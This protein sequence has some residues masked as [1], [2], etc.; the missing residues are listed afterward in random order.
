MG[1]QPSTAET[2]TYASSAT[3]T[4]SFVQTGNVPSDVPAQGTATNVP[5]A[6]VPPTAP[7]DAHSHSLEV[8]TPLRREGWLRLLAKHGLLVKYP[9]LPR[10]IQHGADAG[11]PKIAQT[12]IPPNDPSTCAL[13][14]AFEEIIARE[15]DKGRYLGPFFRVEVE[16]RIGPFQTSPLSMVPKAGKP[17]K[18]R[19][20]QNLS[21]PRNNPD[22]HSIN[23]ALDSDAFP[24][25][26]GTFSTI[27]TLLNNLPP[28]SQGACRDVAE[29]YHIIP[30]TPDQWPGMVVRLSGPDEFAINKCNSF[31]AATAGGLTN[32]LHEMHQL[33]FSR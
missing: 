13:P 6:E 22:T 12:Y 5:A 23:H 25:T 4:T 11:I 8:A 29:A 30:L 18:F 27:C 3:R 2:R 28:G 17:G 16:E 33:I 20:I 31:G 24:C 21:F 10:Y 14:V 9:N 7:K 1:N 26:W 19:L 15:F 32:L